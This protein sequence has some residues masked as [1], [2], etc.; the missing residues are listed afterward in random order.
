MF[1]KL[2]L[3]FDYKIEVEYP[4]SNLSFSFTIYPINFK[5]IKKST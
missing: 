1:N 3:K 4:E 5:K 2:D